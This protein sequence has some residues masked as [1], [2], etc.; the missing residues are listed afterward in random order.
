MLCCPKCRHRTYDTLA[1]RIDLLKRRGKLLKDKKPDPLIV[2]ELLMLELPATV[3]DQCGH[4][5]LRYESIDAGDGRYVDGDGLDDEEWGESRK[6]V[7]CGIAIDPER[8]EVLPDTRQCTQCSAA[9][10]TGQAD[11]REF[12]PKCGSE[13]KLGLRGGRGLAG[14]SMRCSSCG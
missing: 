14:Y 11:E 13:M 10:R 12:C 8:I 1:D 3:C 7:G 6:C 4:V 2:Y 5:G 9:G